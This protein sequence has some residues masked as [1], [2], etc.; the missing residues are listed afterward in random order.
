MLNDS[1]SQIYMQLETLLLFLTREVVQRQLVAFF[2]IVAVAWGVS[3]VIRYEVRPW[4]SAWGKQNLSARYQIY[5]HRLGRLLRYLILP[6][7]GILLLQGM[8]NF[9]YVQLWRGGIL[10]ESVRI[11]WLLLAYRLLLFGLYELIGEK[12]MRA[13]HYRLLAPSFAFIVLWF[14]THYLIDLNLLAQYEIFR[15][16]ETSVTVS[17]LIK[18]FVALYLLFTTAWATRDVLQDFIIPRTTV[19][20][21]LIQVVLQIGSYMV[22]A[23]GVLIVLGTLGVDVSTLAFISGGLSVGLGF[24]MQQIFSNFVSGILLLFEQ[25][26][27][28]GDVIDV[29]GQMGVVNNLSI[30]ATTV[31]TFDNVELIVPNETIL[32]STVTSYT[33]SNRMIRCSVMIGTSYKNN[34]HE[35]I[36]ILKKVA[37]AHPLVRQEPKPAIHFIDFGASSLN[38]RLSVWLDDPLHLTQVTSEL[39][40]KIWDAFAAQGIEIP[41]PQQDIHIRTRLPELDKILDLEK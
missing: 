21:N 36:D 19:D 14:I 29:N 7:V 13:Y 41:F 26:L 8:V 17:R 39:R 33:R 11:L 12:L 30:R 15:I 25:S 34:P 2:L 35:V 5:W 3:E 16:F 38:F 40:L 9:F 27:R 31:T 28:P 18:A 22:I 20:P 32:T 4:L 1:T 6:L 23:V 10:S 24:G 37:L